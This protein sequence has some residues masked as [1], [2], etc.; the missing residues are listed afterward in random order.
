MLRRLLSSSPILMACL[1]PFMDALAGPIPVDAQALLE[2]SAR[3]ASELG[4]VHY[5]AEY[6]RKGATEPE[7]REAVEVILASPH[8]KEG[9][10][11]TRPVRV[12][13]LQQEADQ[14]A[15]VAAFDGTTL[16]HL[17]PDRNL[18][19]EETYKPSGGYAALPL[20]SALLPGLG[21]RELVD[22][23]L[24][25]ILGGSCEV[26]GEACDLVM[27]IE[28]DPFPLPDE[29]GA[30]VSL[31]I[32]TSL[33]ISREGH[34]PLRSERVFVSVFQDGREERRS[35]GCAVSGPMELLAVEPTD[36]SVEL[37]EGFERADM[38]P[39]ERPPAVPVGAAA[40]DWTLEDADGVRH[41]L[42]AQ[43][44]KVVLMDFWA[45]WCGPCKKAMPA[46][47]ALHE[48]FAARG[49]VVYGINSRENDPQAPIE[50]F[51][52]V[53]YTYSSLLQ[54]DEVAAAYG[55][56]GIPHLFLIG[57]DGIVAHQSVGFSPDLEEELAKEIEALL[58][59]K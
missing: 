48:R 58:P 6:W 18:L 14:V 44:G 24:T 46:I 4:A 49:L 59:P 25:P 8:G 40:P 50:Y 41:Q 43:R 9:M 29:E 12:H 22:P 37:P 42:S 56:G 35:Y 54:G 11:M 19:W 23:E 21:G 5:R 57:P 55:V 13:W 3:A 38:S 30:P 7:E 51:K 1:L 20:F 31:R 32:E 33:A 53:G 27:T 26:A 52:E 2:Q 47:Q 36:W 34:L 16:R 17:M 45:T 39:R 28:K 10:P 15:M